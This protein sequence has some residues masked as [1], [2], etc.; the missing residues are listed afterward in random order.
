VLVQGWGGSLIPMARLLSFHAVQAHFRV[1]LLES[2]TT[3][4]P[5][6]VRLELAASDRRCGEELLP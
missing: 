3:Y 4:V 2:G 6:G 5:L 1:G